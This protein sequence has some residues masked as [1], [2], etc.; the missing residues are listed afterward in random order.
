MDLRPGLLPA[1]LANLRSYEPPHGSDDGFAGSD[2]DRTMPTKTIVR[3]TGRGGTR[4]SARVAYLRTLR[5]MPAPL[6]LSR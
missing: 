5:T 2:D 4:R 3:R 6:N 1:G